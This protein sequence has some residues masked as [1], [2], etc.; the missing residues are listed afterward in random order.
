MREPVT[1]WLNGIQAAQFAADKTF[2]S[3][4]TM[5]VFLLWFAGVLMM[6]TA[7]KRLY[8]PVFDRAEK[9][10]LKMGDKL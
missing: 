6:A 4:L 2:L 1:T 3:G 10:F 8:R 7:A 5:E 9:R